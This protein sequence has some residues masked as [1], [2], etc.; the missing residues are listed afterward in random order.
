MTSN[1]HGIAL[2][3]RKVGTQEALLTQLN[4]C[5]HRTRSEL[6]AHYKADIENFE[7][8]LTSPQKQSKVTSPEKLAAQLHALSTPASS[9]QLPSPPNHVN[10]VITSPIPVSSPQQEAQPQVRQHA[11]LGSSLSA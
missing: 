6:I 3:M 11:S 9:M 1:S 5:T 2:P 7:R 8:G 10:S 4:I